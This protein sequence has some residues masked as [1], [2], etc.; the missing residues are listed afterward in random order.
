MAHRA[1]SPVVEPLPSRVMLSVTP[2]L[3][4]RLVG[5]GFER[6]TWGGRDVYV[7]PGEWIVSVAGVRGTAAKQVADVSGR[8]AKLGKGLR[9]VRQL[10]TDGLFQVAAPRGMSGAALR[11]AL[12]Q[13][14]HFEFVEPNG[15]VWAQGIFD[16]RNDPHYGQQYAL[17]NLGT[18]GGLADA[19][20]DAPEAWEAMAGAAEEVVVGVIDTGI[21]YT[22]PDLAPSMWVN[23]FETPG[24]GIDNDLNGFVDDVHGADF[25][26]HDGDPLDEHGHG[27]H[28][29]GIIAAAANNGVGVSGVAPNARLMALQFLDQ[30]G[31]G[32]TDSAIAALNYAANMKARGVNV[33]I[34]N[35]SWGSADDSVALNRAIRNSGDA[36]MLFVAAVGNGG[37]DQLG[38]DND[39]IPFY[40]AS[41]NAPNVVAVAATDNRDLLGGLSNFGL[42]SV[43]LAA[44]GMFVFSTYLNDGYGHMSG[45]SMASPHVAGVAAMAFGLHPDATWQQVRS[46]LL[47]GVD[48]AAGLA[49]KTVTGGRVNALGALRAMERGVV[50]RHVFYNSST[51]DVRSPGLSPDDDTAVATD[52]EPQLPGQTATFANYTSYSRGI[53]G[54]MV[55]LQN[56][57]GPVGGGDF[58]FDVRNAAGDWVPAPVP[59]AVS[60]R[61]G[62]GDRGSDRVTLLWADGAV[63]DTWL[64]VTVLA[65]GA[66]GLAQDD[67][68]YFGN[69]V[70]ETGNSTGDAA[71]TPADFSATRAAQ[72]PGA[73]GITSRYDF[74]RDGAVNAVDLSIVRGHQVSPGLPLITAPGGVQGAAPVQVASAPSDP[75][76]VFSNT[77]ITDERRVVTRRRSA[78]IEL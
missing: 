30:S 60:V 3:A 41:S 34:T 56:P 8:L 32:S 45:T 48:P 78:L 18:S 67:V 55:D 61:A 7:E 59:T 6:M 49:G 27:T 66:T 72:R 4:T 47:R 33:R 65:G 70:G 35:N 24:D 52:K 64:R 16:Q 68:F 22:H 12:R 75:T 21:E 39:L 9:V 28:V 58:A 76:F 77:S 46:A 17:N 14:R 19:D 63:R 15:A 51:F 42:S 25:A 50:G 73:V 5:A 26:H 31:I 23:P 36:G 53:N 74:N 29:A 40:P 62:A 13:V 2:A 71:V 1:T 44:P 37:G 54:V 20:L 57:A 69:A 10:G 43:D 11:A 38:D